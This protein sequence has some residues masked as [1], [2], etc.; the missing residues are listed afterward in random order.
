M[1]SYLFMINHIFIIFIIMVI[2]IDIIIRLIVLSNDLMGIIK[3]GRQGIINQEG[4]I[5]VIKLVFIIRRNLLRVSRSKLE[6]VYGS[7]KLLL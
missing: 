4:I 1:I 2:R 5:R 6:L 3:G 7:F